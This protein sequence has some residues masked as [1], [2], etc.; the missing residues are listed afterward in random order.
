MIDGDDGFDG[1]ERLLAAM[2]DPARAAAYY[3]SLFA[4]LIAGGRDTDDDDERERYAQQALI[5]SCALT[6][7]RASQDVRELKTLLLRRADETSSDRRE[8]IEEVVDLVHELA[9][10]IKTVTDDGVRRVLDGRCET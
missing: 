7:A 5:V 3:T 1:F 6:A 8:Q 9:E 10:T 4:E 2:N